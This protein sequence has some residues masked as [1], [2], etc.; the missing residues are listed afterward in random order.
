MN[1]KI[2]IEECIKE[3]PDIIV[4]KHLIDG[5]SFFLND[6][7][8]GEEFEFK[9]DLAISLDVHIRD[10][11]IVGSG[12]LGFSIKPEENIT[13]FFYRYKS[14][15]FDFEEDIEKEKS[16]LDIAIVSG[17]LF[18]N[19]LV[20]LYKHTDH[21]TGTSF[22]GGNK[23]SLANYIL[24]GWFR[25]DFSPE[26]YLITP[27]IKLVQEKYRMKYGRKINIGVYKSWFFFETY[28][29]NN[30]NNIKLNLIANL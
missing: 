15:D 24:K 23:K 28:H 6:M 2:F 9:K 27:Q 29:Q 7:H 5:T 30:I 10:I 16:D 25:P 11:V 26:N 3:S 17:K 12:K 19:I 1:V 22:E 8:Q 20:N 4:Q 18:D 21:Y 14:F 13:P